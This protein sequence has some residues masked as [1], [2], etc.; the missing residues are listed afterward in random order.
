MKELPD[1]VL[2]GNKN[3]VFLKKKLD[4]IMLILCEKVNISDIKPSN[5]IIEGHIGH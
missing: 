5:S 1:G 4:F 2:I 3:S